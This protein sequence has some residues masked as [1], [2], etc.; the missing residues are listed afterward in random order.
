VRRL[1]V[2][3]AIGQLLAEQSVYEIADVLPEVRPGRS[4]LPVDARF[5]LAGEKAIA[6]ALTRTRTLP[7]HVIADAAECQ[8]RL[9]AR[10][11]ETEESK[12][13]Q[14]VHRGVPTVVP[15]GTTPPA[16]GCLQREQMRG[17]ALDSSLSALGSDFV[18]RRIGQVP[19]HLPANR[20]IGIEQPAQHRSLGFG[21]S[22]PVWHQLDLREPQSMCTST[23]APE[24][25][26]N[27]TR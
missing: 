25:L 24:R 1:A 3:A 2:P 8:S 7:R 9:G 27:G 5:Y 26:S 4:H 16:V 23:A 14:D 20:G 22:P 21:P 18:R 15:S 6:F 19:H 10:G 17:P 13:P 11:I 12:Q